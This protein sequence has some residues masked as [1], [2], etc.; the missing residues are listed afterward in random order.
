MSHT[1]S[2]HS[3]PTFSSSRHFPGTLKVHL[4]AVPHTYMYTC[5]SMCLMHMYYKVLLYGEVG[6]S[7]EHGEK[8]V[9]EGLGDEEGVGEWNGDE[10]DY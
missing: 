4:Q 3:A 5:T 2:S 1:P 8:G 10:E 9:G 6:H 7:E